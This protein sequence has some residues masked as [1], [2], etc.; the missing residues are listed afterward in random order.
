MRLAKDDF[1]TLLKEPLVDRIDERE[2]VTRVQ[3]GALLLDV[4]LDSEFRRA[5]LKGSIN[6][7]LSQLRKHAASLST[8]SKVIV[9]CDTGRRSTAAAFLL[10]ERG[11]D[12]AVLQ[13]GINALIKANPAAA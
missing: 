3:A 13:N 4:R 2:T 9:Y 10:S 8:G 7:P 5:N 11:F 1:L 6:V 12:V